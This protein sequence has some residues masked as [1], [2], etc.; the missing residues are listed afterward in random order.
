MNFEQRKWYAAFMEEKEI[1]GF[2]MAYQ[3]R[4]PADPDYIP[5]LGQALYN[6]TYLEWIVVW[7]IVKLS[8]NGFDAVPTGKPGGQIATALIQAIENTSPPLPKTLRLRLVKFHESYLAVY[9]V[10]TNY[11]THTHILQQKA[12]ATRWRRTP[13]AYP[14]G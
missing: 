14:V 7:T 12:S 13:M 3:S 9:A 10:E 1:G 5:A 8:H 11:F 4:I 2:D 6:F